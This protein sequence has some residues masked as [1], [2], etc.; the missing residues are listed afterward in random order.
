LALLGSHNSE[1][2]RGQRLMMLTYRSKVV[3]EFDPMT[4]ELSRALPIHFETQEVCNQIFKL[5]HNLMFLS[6]Y[7]TV[8]CARELYKGWGL[9]FDGEHLLATDGSSTLYFFD[10]ATL[11]E[12]RRVQVSYT[13]RPCV[14]MLRTLWYSD[15]GRVHA[16]TSAGACREWPAFGAVER[17]RAR[18]PPPACVSNPRG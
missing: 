13:V 7:S 17:T 10:P 1:S 12:V 4:L 11:K 8:H 2:P 15:S 9:A 5:I 16:Q 18:S 6:P 3:L 14:L